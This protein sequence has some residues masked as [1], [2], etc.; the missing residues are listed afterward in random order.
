MR[1]LPKKK[2]GVAEFLEILESEAIFRCTVSLCNNLLGLRG[3]SPLESLFVRVTIFMSFFM[4]STEFE[5][6][7]NFHRPSVMK[8]ETEAPGSF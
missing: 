6:S 5:T 1:V 3:G 7:D 4:L 8:Q 2:S